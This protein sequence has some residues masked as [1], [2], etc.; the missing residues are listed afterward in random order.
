MAYPPIRGSSTPRE[1][2]STTCR[3]RT[4][5]SATSSDVAAERPPAPRRRGEELSCILGA[6]MPALEIDPVTLPPEEQKEIEGLLA[7]PK[8]LA[9]PESGWSIVGWILVATLGAASLGLLFWQGLGIVASPWATRGQWIA[10]PYALATAMLAIGTFKAAVA[11][12]MQRL[13]WKPGRYLLT[14]GFIDARCRPLRFLP[15]ADFTRFEIHE[16]EGHST[17]LRFFT[18]SIHFGDEVENFHIAGFP[19]NVPRVALD[20]LSAHRDAVVDTQR[21]EGGYRFSRC[22]GAGA[23]SRQTRKRLRI[24]DHLWKASGI[25]GLLAIVPIYFA[26][27]PALSLRA[28][29]QDGSVR[30]LRAAAAA[31]PYGWVIARVRAAIHPRFEAARAGVARG[32]AAERRA[33]VE[34]LLVYLEDH[35][36]ATVRVRLVI[37]GAEQLAAA[38]RGLEERIKGIP[39][40]A[41]A[42]V[43]LNY[44]DPVLPGIRVGQNEFAYGLRWPFRTVIPMDLLDLE[45]EPSQFDDVALDPRDPVIE[46]ASAIEPM[47]V[48]QGGG[49]RAYYAALAF[50]YETSLILPGEPKTLLIPKFVVPPPADLGEKRRGR[51]GHI[52]TIF[53]NMDDEAIYNKQAEIASEAGGAKLA[54]MLLAP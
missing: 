27:L 11:I 13:P 21:S 4:S 54:K 1:A 38:T 10:I 12:Q 44:R 2:P 31:Y 18:M 24:S 30:A 3:R 8:I 33:P 20:E 14:Q 6:A 32:I 9:E 28:A 17:P 35:D 22:A 45:S 51:S 15:I 7:G 39:G 40:A 16:R 49:E 43:V 42:P 34:R 19:Q 41:A 23:P 26:V 29:E 25:A 50:E 47:D 46:I 5:S 53:D 52:W 48:F 36:R 37:P